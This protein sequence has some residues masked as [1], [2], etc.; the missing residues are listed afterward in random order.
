MHY[1]LC[2]RLPSRAEP[3]TDEHLPGTF[4]GIRSSRTICRLPK[5]HCYSKDALDRVVGTPTNPRPDG[6]TRDSQ[7]RR[8]HITQR[9][10]D[11]HGVTPG[12]LRCEVRG[13]RSHFETSRKRF[14][15]IEK[16]KLD[17]Q[18]QEDTRNAEPPLV[19]T[20]EMEVEQ[21]Q[22]KSSQ[23][24]VLMRC[25]WRFTEPSGSTRPLGGG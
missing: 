23:V 6:A 17:K 13:T 14:D 25:G 19:T 11:E 24:P 21:P 20:V 4:A 10:V 15:A 3:L 9:R 18:L 12:C 16:E 2:G 8:Q 1:K 22:A 5:I 7:V